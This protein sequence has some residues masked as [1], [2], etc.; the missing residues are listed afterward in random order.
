[1]IEEEKTIC[2]HCGQK[3]KKWKTPAASTWGSEFQYICFNDE[4]PYF[5]RGWDWTMKT[6]KA[7]AS[8]RH[9]YNPENGETGPLPVWSYDALKCDIIE[10]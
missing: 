6:M 8:Y 9:R 5:V 1:M 10:E 3:M 4:C 7:K 2:P